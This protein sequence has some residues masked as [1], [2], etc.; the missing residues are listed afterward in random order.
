M[1]YATIAT[2]ALTALSPLVKIGFEKGFEKL[3]EKTAEA[4]F[5]ERQAIWEKIKGL[6]Q[7]D[8]LTLLN[9]L[10]DAG[11]DVKAQGKLEGKLETH[12]EAH[13]EVAKDLETILTKLK[14]SS[15]TKITN[16]EIADSEI[17]NRLKRD[18]GQ[19]GEAVINNSDVSG[20]KIDNEMEIS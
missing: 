11:S 4:G 20:S 8:D 1:D 7:A 2:M 3:G 19:R 12:L 18:A 10:Q 15:S 5:N 13:P 9:L 14:E 17:K 16:E 6:F